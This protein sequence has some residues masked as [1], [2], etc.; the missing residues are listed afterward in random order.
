MSYGIRG[1]KVEAGRSV[2]SRTARQ[3]THRACKARARKARRLQTKR[4]IQEN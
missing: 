1:F 2:G 3:D 4:I